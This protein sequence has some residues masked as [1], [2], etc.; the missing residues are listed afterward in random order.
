MSSPLLTRQKGLKIT[1][2]QA[3][4]GIDGCALGDLIQVSKGLG[5]EDVDSGGEGLSSRLE[6]STSSWVRVCGSP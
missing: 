1:H 3:E 5:K 6:A 2:I 4:F